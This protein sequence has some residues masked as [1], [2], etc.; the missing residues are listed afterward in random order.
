MTITV[1]LN[2]PQVDL[3]LTAVDNPH[4][5]GS[6]YIDRSLGVPVRKAAAALITTGLMATSSTSEG[7]LR[8]T[9]HGREIAV[10]M[11]PSALDTVRDIADQ[12][13][14]LLDGYANQ[15]SLIV[16]V[17]IGCQGGRHR[18]VVVAESVAAWLRRQNIGVDVVHEHIDR[19]VVERS[20]CQR[21]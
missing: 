19:P 18:S 10:L 4:V 2:G 9:D 12:V 7:S 16:Q 21:D 6:V 13:V 5:R 17:W 8:L 3:L 1:H 11:H 14:A 15:R 20:A